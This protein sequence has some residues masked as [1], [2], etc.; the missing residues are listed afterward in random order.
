MNPLWQPTVMP[1]MHLQ[2]PRGASI[3]S[4]KLGDVTG[5]GF[6]DLV[7]LT[8][9]R[10]SD[11]PFLTNI[12]LY[13]KFGRTN[14]IEM[15]RLPENVG[16]NPT[17]WLGDLTNDGVNDIFV[18]I[19]SGGSGAIIYAYIY[20]MQNGRI[21]N[22][23]DSIKFNEQHGYKVQYE[24]H[25]KAAV[26]SSSPNK[27]YILDL[28]YK[29]EE[30]L[31]EIYHPNGTLIQPIEGWV[32]PLSALYPVDIGRNG[33]YGLLGLQ[34]IAGRYHADGLG[35]VENQLHWDGRTFSIVRQSVAI[36][37]EG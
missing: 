2:I 10:Q 34:L 37:G 19:D 14:H 25:Y 11:S 23:F 35:Y 3:I 1:P 32:D 22:I 4:Y 7:Y 30:Y 33:K 21:R 26:F 18:V 20:S 5:D 12:T 31:N 27:K 36:P 15:F 6:P 28:Q 8:A 9:E 13:V 17:I 16:Y 29:G 24:D